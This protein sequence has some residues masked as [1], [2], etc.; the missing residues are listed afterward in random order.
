[1]DRRIRTIKNKRDEKEMIETERLFIRK[2]MVDDWRD[3]CEYLSLQETYTFEPGDPVTEEGAKQIAFER[4]REDDFLAVILKKEKKLIGH[5]YFNQEEPKEF[6]TWEMGFIF[7]PAFQNKG[8]CTEAARRIVE[9]AR[10]ELGA[11]RVVAYC[12]PLNPAS[13]RVLEK[14]GMT[15]EGYFKKKGFF[16]KDKHGNPLWFDCYAYGMLLDDH[17]VS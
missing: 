15:R 11:H 10:K 8:Y 2:F 4:A 13:W 5:V 12:N 1:M 14:I 6:L 16:R 3:L 17:D 9:Y 7:N